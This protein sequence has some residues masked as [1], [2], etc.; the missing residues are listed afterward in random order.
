MRKPLT[1]FC[2]GTIKA[3][4]GVDPV[5]SA[6]NHNHPTLVERLDALDKGLDGEEG[7]PKEGKKEL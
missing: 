1:V 5:Y 3:I 7:K 4:Y 2:L 6:Y